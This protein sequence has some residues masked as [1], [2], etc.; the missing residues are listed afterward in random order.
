MESRS[1]RRSLRSG[2]NRLLA[3]LAWRPAAGVD[4]PHPGVG[5]ARL[6]GVE[7]Q[8]GPRP[9]GCSLGWAVADGGGGLCLEPC[10]PELGG[11]PPPELRP[12]QREAGRPEFKGQVYCPLWAGV[13]ISLCFKESELNA[14]L[15]V[16]GRRKYATVCL[17]VVCT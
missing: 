14:C 17:V 4:P 16:V 6:A 5:E 3:P 9:F 8:S 12:Q 13:F 2:E 1:L 10:L 15:P 7:V 11:G